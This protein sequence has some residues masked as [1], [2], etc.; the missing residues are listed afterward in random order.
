MFFKYISFLCCLVVTI[1][2]YAQQKDIKAIYRE[3]PKE[4]GVMKMNIPGWLARLGVNLSMDKE[5]RENPDNATLRSLLKKLRNVR[6]M[7]VA[8]PSEKL[9]QRV[10]SF[11]QSK[12]N[13]SHYKEIVTVRA[14]ETFVNVWM[15]DKLN[16]RK[17]VRYIK[18]LFV[19]VGEEQQLTVISIK[20]KWNLKMLLDNLNGLRQLP[21][22][23]GRKSVR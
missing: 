23:F 15:C 2:G 1:S 4:Q 18:N 8:N 12:K 14:Q 13:N 19:S 22:T 9:Y 3:Q 16:K 17:G 6:L 20:G 21:Q 11:G 7:T 5:E 10:R